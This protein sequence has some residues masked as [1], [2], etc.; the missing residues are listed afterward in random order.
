M[1]ISKKTN[2]I[3]CV[4]L[5]DY[6]NN[7]LKQGEKM[8]RSTNN[9][10]VKQLNRNRVFRYVNSVEKTSMP[11]ISAALGISVPT[12]LTI[13]NELKKAGVIREVGELESNGG[14]KAKAI[15]SVKD[16]RFAIGL[17]ITRNHVGIVYTDLSGKALRHER[18]HKPFRY[19]K[20][21]FREVAEIVDRFIEESHV[22]KER[23]LGIGVSV[24]GII[25][26]QKALI[27]KSHA[28]RIHNVPCDELTEF[29]PLPCELI[30]DANA[31]MIAEGRR[32][33]RN[34]NMVY[35]SLSNTVGGAVVFYSGIE[36]NNMRELQ[37]SNV[38]NMYQ[39]D[40]WRSC[41]FGHMVIHPGGERCYCGKEGCLDA[42]CSALKLADE[43][44]GILESFFH[45]M[46]AGDERLRRIWDEYLDNLAIA[47][48]NLRMSFDCGLILGGYVGSNMEPYIQELR[49]KVAERNIFENDGT[50]VYACRYQKE[51]SALGAAIHE[52]EKYINTI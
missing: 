14:R 37:N 13:V 29:M 26:E 25:D 52:M 9:L 49:R 11:E 36:N 32:N 17:D 34:D 42:Y 46:E 48:D 4:K 21:Y 12:V 50:Y 40:N 47:V 38:V 51:A 27:T 30:N 31:A 7:L 44:D 23:V 33:K 15:A 45:K 16:I 28:L 10:E 18:I 5:S 22:S 19:E 24:P 39:G 35:L 1:L 41:E 20:D 3:I 8:K 2:A 43:T 6:I